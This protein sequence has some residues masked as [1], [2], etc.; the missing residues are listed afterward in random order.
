VLVL[1]VLLV[2]IPTARASDPSLGTVLEAE[3]SV[4]PA[5]QLHESSASDGAFARAVTVSIAD[6]TVPSGTYL[7]KVKVR[8]AQARRIELRV[9]GLTVGSY[10][11][12]T[13]WQIFAATV[14]L[15]ASDA[16]GVASVQIPGSTAAPGTVDVDWIAL[17]PIA[18]VATVK[19]N[20]ILPMGGV[21]VT[22]KGINFI[23]LTAGDIA[24]NGRVRLTSVPVTDLYRWGAESVRLGLNQE[25]WLSNC[26]VVLDYDHD[27]QTDYRTAVREAVDALTGLGMQVLLSLTV[28][29][30]G[31][32]TGCG[33]TVQPWLKEAPDTRSPAFWGA[34]ATSFGN[35]PLVMFDLFNEPNHISA[36]VWR[37]GGPVSYTYKTATGLKRTTTYQAVSMQALYNAVRDTGAMNLITVS[38]TGWATQPTVLESHPLNGY[39]IIAGVHSY[40]SECSPDD[41]H[42]SPYLDQN[43]PPDFMA[44]HAVIITES[45]WKRPPDPRYNRALIDWAASHHVAYDVYNFYFPGD[46]SVVSDWNPTLDLGGGAS[47]KPPGPTGAPVWND[48]S[49][50]RVARGF[51]ALPLSGA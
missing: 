1:A 32:N 36:D 24:P 40:C 3:R 8:A 45:G 41:P 33:A 13:T 6:T 9:G 46:Y 34:V 28:T 31:K 48:M 12:G 44:D 47:T 14:Q 37:K 51:P 42:L 23:G 35:N 17:A 50:A 19:G 22:P 49:R 4:P 25:Y 30:R 29:E 5:Q 11:T 26:P 38:G 7:M 16:V 39:G 15:A 10:A 20:E 27:E 18:Q 2:A 21:P 43:T